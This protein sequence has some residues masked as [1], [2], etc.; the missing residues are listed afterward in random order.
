MLYDET[1]YAKLNVQQMSEATPVQVLDDD[2]QRIIRAYEQNNDELRKRV[3]ELEQQIQSGE[4]NLK[5]EVQTLRHRI[6]ELQ[7]ASDAAENYERLQEEHIN[8]VREMKE[9]E[10]TL[11]EQNQLLQMENQ[12]LKDNTVSKWDNDATRNKNIL[13]VLNSLREAYIQGQGIEEALDNL[14]A[15]IAPDVLVKRDREISNLKSKNAGKIGRKPGRVDQSNLRQQQEMQAMREELEMLKAKMNGPKQSK[16]PAPRAGLAQP[17]IKAP[18]KVKD[19]ETKVTELQS[20]LNEANK[21]IANLKSRA[22]E[23]TEKIR[24]L[25][26]QLQQAQEDANEAKRKHQVEAANKSVERAGLEA[27]LEQLKEDAK[28]RIEY[29]RARA[30]LERLEAEVTELRKPRPTGAAALDRVL[31][32]ISRMEG[33]IIQRQMTL[34]RMAAQLEDKFADEKRE[35]ENKHKREI[36]EKNSQLRR[37]KGEFESILADL[38]KSKKRRPC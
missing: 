26:E 9:R 7:A 20:R 15:I 2:A 24:Q 18:P 16:L 4:P 38:E 25:T 21:E 31:D 27:Q 19:L 36:E 5:S 12:Q 3:K 29:E 14:V 35:I 33:D 30:K 13:S 37:L 22:K 28:Y 34:S 10:M 1:V 8:Y 11:R 6:L 17:Q 32:A 23:R